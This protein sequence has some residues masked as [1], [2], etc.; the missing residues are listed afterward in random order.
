MDLWLAISDPGTRDEDAL[1]VYTTE[2]LALEVASLAT[3]PDQGE[4]RHYVLDE[5]PDWI[6][7]FVAEQKTLEAE[8]A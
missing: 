1:G 7:G 2:E 6:E 5:V 4:A 8:L 3:Y